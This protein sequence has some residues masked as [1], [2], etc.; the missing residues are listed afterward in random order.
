MTWTI[1]RNV[2]N[3]T[4]FQNLNIWATFVIASPMLSAKPSPSSNLEFGG[5]NYE[6]I[7]I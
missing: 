2:V 3:N 4:L 1:L 5:E 7:A 6:E